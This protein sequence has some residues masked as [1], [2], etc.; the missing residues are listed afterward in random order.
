MTPA[1]TTSSPASTTTT[2]TN[3]LSETAL[4]KRDFSKK[5]SFTHSNS[6]PIRPDVNIEDLPALRDEPASKR[7]QL[8]IQ[9]LRQCSTTF[10]FNDPNSSK[11]GKDKKR[12]ILLEL[13]DYIN[14]PAGQAIFNSE[15]V[16]LEIVGTIKANIG[17]S[18][19]P[20]NLEFDPEEDE[21]VLEPSWPHL[22][23]VYEFFLRFI[24]SG[25]V[26]AKVAKKY[27][28]PSLALI[29]INLFDSE[30]PRERDY[31]KTILH[32]IYGKFM[33]HRSFIRKN[34]SNVFYTFVYETGRH[35]GIGELLE[36]L[37]SI[38]NG[39]AI[40]LKK[41]H[42]TFLQ[43]ALLPLHKPKC[44]S[45][46]HQQLSYCVIQYVEKDPETAIT[47]IRGLISMWPWSDSQKQVLMIN[48]LEEIL[49]LLGYDQL[50]ELQVELFGFLAK[51]VGSAHFQVA[52]R[53]LFLW[54][55]EHLVNSGCLSRQLA[56]SIL[57][58]IYV[59]LQE[60]CSHWNQT[61]EGLAQSVQKMYV[62][63]DPMLYD[64]CSK[65]CA[66]RVEDRIVKEEGWK[67]EWERIGEQIKAK[68]GA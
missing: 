56:E 60:K 6:T 35:N 43:R 15:A 2:L 16:M 50:Q 7:E 40:P 33:T 39:F 34:I 46:Y 21:P 23:V 31:L 57:P 28:D 27:I 64:N 62:E 5:S 4:P 45:L 36:I 8:F 44:I 41:E 55:N 25:E 13:V 54:N 22:Q 32:R 52:E 67:Q 47:V 48:E 49:E 17:R 1:G 42:L 10:D 12:Q 53:S 29:L 38:I 59:P 51:L 65:N 30:D 58:Q 37:G 61:V 19:P 11:S 20:A 66:K 26:S 9:K 68:G 24:V 14:T 63:F 18:L 3:P